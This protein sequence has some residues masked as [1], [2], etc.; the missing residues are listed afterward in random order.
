MS[1]RCEREAASLRLLLP[2]VEPT[3][4][5][6][7]C[8]A[9]GRREGGVVEIVAVSAAGQARSWSDV[10][11]SS[12]SLVERGCAI[13]Y[14]IADLSRTRSLYGLALSSL[15]MLLL[16]LLPMLLLL[17]LLLPVRM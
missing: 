14:A 6:C 3:L 4:G 7:L 13:V 11:C 1:S 5:H 10:N 8:W 15:P 9:W 16:L 12:S 2:L 17:L